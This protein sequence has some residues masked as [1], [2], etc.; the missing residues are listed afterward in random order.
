[1]LVVAAAGYG[2]TTALDAARP[3]G[4]RVLTA[5]AA[6]EGDLA[7]TV[8]TAVDGLDE[9]TAP[10]LR[11]LLDRV[12][13]APADHT[14]VLASRAPLTE[15]QRALLRGQVYDRGAAD[16]ALDQQDVARVLREEY[17]VTDPGVAVRVRT[18]TAGWPALVHLAGDALAAGAD[19]ASLGTHEGDLRTWV[20]LNVLDGLGPEERGL[21]ELGVQVGVLTPDLAVHLGAC[22]EADRLG[23]SADPTTGAAAVRR[24][25]RSGLLVPASYD[26][27]LTVV[28]VVGRALSPA[29]PLTGA[30]LA[31]AASLLEEAGLVLAA[32]QCRARA[33]E[34]EELHRL[35]AAHGERILRH[36]EAAEVIVLVRADPEP[37]RALRLL[38]ADAHR[39]CGDAAMALHLLTEL[40]SDPD[41]R[42]RHV[43]VAASAHYQRGS[44]DA[45]RDSLDL[46]APTATCDGED[47][48]AWWATR[49]QVLAALGEGQPATEAADRALALATRS[50]AAVARVEA[51]LARARVSAGAAKDH[52]H[53]QAL[54]AAEL[55]GDRVSTA[56]VLANRSCTLLAAARAAEAAEVGR[57]AVALADEV[58]P[59][60]L[61]AA[62][63]HNLGEALTLTGELD[64]ARWMLDRGA[65]LGDRLGPARQATALLG[66]ARLDD[67][68]GLHQQ[69]RSTFAEAVA[70]ARCSG[71]RQVLVPALVG[72]A[73]ALVDDD[74]EAARALAREAVSSAPAGLLAHALTGLGWVE[75]AQGRTAESSDLAARAIA[76]AR[77]QGA[78]APLADALELLALSAGDPDSAALREAHALWLRGG[79]T[80]PAARVE[81]LLGRRP[82]ADTVTRSRAR[83]AA[84]LLQ[85]TGLTTLHGTP[86]GDPCGGRA[87]RITVLGGFGVHVDGQPVPHTAWRS[88]QAR[89]LVKVLAA[90][91]GRPRTRGHLCEVLWP[92]DDPAR[93]G[94]RLSVLLATVRGVLDPD[95]SWPADRYL[96]A[97]LTGIRLDLRH[98]AVD[99]DDLIHDEA[100]AAELLVAGETD[101]AREILTA[102]DRGYRGDAFE[103]DPYETWADALREEARAAW[104]RSAMRLARLH[105]RAGRAGDAQALLLRVL[106]VDP[107]DEQAHSLLVRTHA[108]AGRH[109]E[110]QR[111]FGRWVDAMRSIEAPAPDR[112]VLT[113]L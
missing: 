16:L 17:A 24:L 106:L 57:R 44:F 8:W 86:L 112:T 12:A 1:M 65:G 107:Y 2:K 33:G 94:H 96:A 85:R 48:V 90:A 49:A 46:A 45:A 111:A 3:D 92:D 84:R 102:L 93:T 42:V 72:L 30:D 99:A 73:R 76:E 101:V 63:L 25:H 95:R 89:T 62:A 14:V 79:A 28:P 22:T 13:A 100:R 18:L 53:E 38:E 64:E 113:S 15:E 11:A 39:R 70:L 60:G 80:L 50:G 35:L 36:G 104:L 6:V 27:C 52:H 108:R 71:E 103:E 32:A 21:L 29:A 82:D 75:L 109:G 9:L 67:Q 5:G 87:V 78:V 20:R 47:A 37:P 26:G 56:R 98:V 59:P 43:I 110:A 81:V 66:L 41:D 61:L 58:S 83:E 68:Q 40:P 19:V 34:R 54:L 31:R 74:Q 91:R 51:H 97:D 77:D 4:G 105:G 7:A 88:R 23:A 55:A 69:A 10:E